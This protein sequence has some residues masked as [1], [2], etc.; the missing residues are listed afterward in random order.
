M[1]AV[2]KFWNIPEL[3]EG[4][5][6]LLGPLST[7][8]LIESNVMD[9][10]ILQK[11][12]TFAAWTNLIRGSSSDQQGL[13]MEE[14]DVRVLVKILHFM[15]LEEPSTFLMNPDQARGTLMCN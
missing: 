2:G 5:V 11:S 12:L 8:R 1:D 6:F 14:G 7:L 13:M 4:L 3:G 10:E 9:K 15:E